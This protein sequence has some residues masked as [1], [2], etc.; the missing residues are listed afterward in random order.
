MNVPM[1]EFLYLEDRVNVTVTEFSYVEDMLN[2]TI[3]VIISGE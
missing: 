2:A 1:T 3:S